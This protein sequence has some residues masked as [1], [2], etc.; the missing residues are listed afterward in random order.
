MV[1]LVNCVNGCFIFRIIF[2]GDDLDVG[3]LNIKSGGDQNWHNWSIVGMAVL[4]VKFDQRAQQKLGG[5]ELI[6]RG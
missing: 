5:L 4:L 3:D 1:Q 2:V 6:T